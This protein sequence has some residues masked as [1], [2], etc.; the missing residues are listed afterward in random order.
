MGIKHANT[1]EYAIRDLIV[2]AQK[3]EAQG[4]EIIKLNIGD[5]NSFD[6]DTPDFIKEAFIDAIKNGHNYY[7][8]SA[9]LP[10]LREAIVET[11]KK[12]NGVYLDKEKTIITNGISE[13]VD[14]IFRAMI[15]H[16]DD[17]LIP[18]PSYPPYTSYVRL[19]GGV[20]IEYKCVESQGWHPDMDD[21]EKKITPRTKAIV[22]IS[23][24]NPTGA[25][26]P[27]KVLQQIVNLAAENDIPIISDEIYDEMSY[28]KHV[29]PCALSSDVKFIQLNGMSKGYLATGWRMGYMSVS[30]G[31]EELYD[32]CIKQA[33]IRLCANTPAQF[34]YLAALRG[35]K[36]HVEEVK[37]K[38]RE[39]RDYAYKRLNEIEGTTAT[40]PEGT[41]YIFPKITHPE[42]RKDDKK[43]VLDLLHKK[44]VLFVNGS[45]F[46][47]EFG[48]GHFRAVFLPKVEIL[49]EA[50]NRLEEFLTEAK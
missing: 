9:G 7:E 46:G 21:L 4:K 45:G 8:D 42:Y 32:G 12:E 5:P 47:K 18:G 38:L 30:E 16:G 41:F 31:L 2:P 35:S 27:K 20:P 14:F 25:V 34:A 50:F 26:Y 28:K 10:E 17:I 33:R 43:F 37:N 40:M 11:E 48:S 44:F 13:A 36:A 23:P 15:D 6:F 39:R 3:L 1:I 49:E 29:S 22:I 19:Y 24:N